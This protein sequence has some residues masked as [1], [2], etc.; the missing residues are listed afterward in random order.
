MV[1]SLFF[2]GILL[3][4]LAAYA[5]AYSLKELPVYQELRS[6]SQRFYR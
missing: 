1:H 4:I 6:R 3:S 2:I 5:A